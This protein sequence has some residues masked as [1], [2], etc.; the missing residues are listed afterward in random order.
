MGKG[1]TN[2]A[3]TILKIFLSVFIFV[4]AETIAQTSTASFLYWQPSA[5][6]YSMGGIGVA[7]Q[8][9]VYSAYYNP[10]GLVFSKRITITGSFVN[11]F[12]FFGSTANS[13]VGASFKIDQSN[14]IALTANLFW[15]GKQIRTGEV[16]PE[17]LKIQT[18][19]FHWEIKLSYSRLISE[20]LSAGISFGML[21]IN[22]TEDPV[23][24]EQKLGTVTT[25]LIDGG[26]L[27][28]NLIPEATLTNDN[29]KKDYSP[30]LQWLQNYGESYVSN[31]FAVGM[32]IS[33]LGPDISYI[34]ADQSDPPPA[35]LLLGFTYTPISLN[36]IRI[37]I[38]TDLEKR[39]NESNTLDYVHFGGEVRIFK[40]LNFRVGYFSNTIEDGFSYDTF[41]AG[42]SLKF[43]SFNLARYN[44]SLESTWHFDSIIS[45]EF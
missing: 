15:M 17:P 44:R 21:N 4:A 34:D 43:I 3:Q 22:L 41:G 7:N 20:N 18:N 23:G 37:L 38:G 24:I 42:I 10:A 13:F 9:D 32:S 31:G 28:R 8:N 30:F 11:P 5:K 35:K 33:N 45:L 2:A 6:S 16:S 12:P 19:P 27:L 14:A 36:E 29:K 26:V 39:L 40:V 25:V 1:K